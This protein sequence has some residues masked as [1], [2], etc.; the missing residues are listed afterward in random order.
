MSMPLRRAMRSGDRHQSASRK[1]V[2]IMTERPP[3]V[4]RAGEAFDLEFDDVPPHTE[5][6]IVVGKDGENSYIEYARPDG[7]IRR[8]VTVEGGGHIRIRT[9]R[10]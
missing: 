2:G 5:L 1:G 10:Q 6:R 9:D 3:V 4:I 8:L 7:S